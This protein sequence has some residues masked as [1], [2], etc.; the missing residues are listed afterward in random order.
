MVEVRNAR[1]EDAQRLLEIYTPYVTHTAV[2]FEYEVPDP[3][4]GL[5]V[6]PNEGREANL[7]YVMSNSLGFGGHNAALILKKWGKN[8][9]WIFLFVVVF[10]NIRGC[11]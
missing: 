9:L 4:I 5:D 7:T 10:K 1:P 2:S 8:E 3:E 6:V 11:L